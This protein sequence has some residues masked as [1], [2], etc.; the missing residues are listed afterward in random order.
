VKAA[1]GLSGGGCMQM[2]RSGSCNAQPCVRCAQLPRQQGGVGAGTTLASP[3]WKQ[4]CAASSEQHTD[5]APQGSGPPSLTHTTLSG[6]GLWNCQ[7]A[8]EVLLLLS[9]ASESRTVAARPTTV[10]I[11][12]PLTR[13]LQAAG[14][15]QSVSTG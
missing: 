11:N 5:R 6:R 8:A 15:R 14:S 9:T 13:D 1:A 10:N 3:I 4:A 12:L 7:L 2:C